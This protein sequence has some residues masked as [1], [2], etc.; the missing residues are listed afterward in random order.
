MVDAVVPAQIPSWGQGTPSPTPSLQ[1]WAAHRC[2]LLQR[3]ADGSHCVCPSPSPPL[4]TDWVRVKSLAHLVL[5]E[6]KSKL[7]SSPGYETQTSLQLRP[8]PCWASVSV[9][10][11]VPLWLPHKSQGAKRSQGLLPSS[12][13]SHRSWRESLTYWV[14][15]ASAKHFCLPHF[16]PLNTKGS[17][18]Q[19]CGWASP[20]VTV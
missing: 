4:G 11:C 2:P 16:V 12:Q 14:V 18:A 1:G 9:H 19:T 7:Q 6:T 20:K 8:Q 17:G 3:N 15:R 13:S 5:L 10:F